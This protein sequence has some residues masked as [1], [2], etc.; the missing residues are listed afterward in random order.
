MVKEKEVVRKVFTLWERLECVSI[1]RKK[2][3]KGKKKRGKQDNLKKDF[4]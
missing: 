4:V 3:G 2:K 1:G